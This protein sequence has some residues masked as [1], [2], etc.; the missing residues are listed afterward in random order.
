MRRFG[1]CAFHSFPIDLD[2]TGVQKFQQANSLFAQVVSRHVSRNYSAIWVQDYHL[3]L[4]PALLRN[5]IPEG[6]C[7]KIG[8]FL[9][10]PFPS[11]E[12]FR[13]SPVRSELLMGLLGSDLVG[14][15]TFNDARHFTSCCAMVLGV[16]CSPQGVELSDGHFASVGTFPGTTLALSRFR[17]SSRATQPSGH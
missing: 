6:V 3:F 10:S 2:L 16:D 14:F 8:F 9:H 7:P 5:E 12:I 15:Q 11:S 1:R 4:L 17:V 13:T